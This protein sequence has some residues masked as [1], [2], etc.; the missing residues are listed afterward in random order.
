MATSL[1][2]VVCVA[3]VVEK[4]DEVDADDGD[5]H[6]DDIDD[7]GGGGDGRRWRWTISNML[8]MTTTIWKM[9]MTMM[10]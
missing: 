3:I 2:E 10:G 9:V 1:M 7:A 6:I 5:E 8:V 4:D